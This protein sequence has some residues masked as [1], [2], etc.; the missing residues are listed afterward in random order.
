MTEYPILYTAIGDSITLGTGTILFS[1]TFVDFYASAL[2]RAT[3][4]CVRSRIYARNGSTT[5]DVKQALAS[6]TISLNNTSVVTLTAGGNDLIDAMQ[7]FVKM[8]DKS[9]LYKALHHCCQNMNWIVDY[10]S[11][12]LN[13]QRDNYMIRVVNLYNPFPNLPLANYWVQAFNDHIEDCSIEEHVKVADVFTLFRGREEKLL[14]D[15]GIHPNDEG[16]KVIAKALVET[17]ICL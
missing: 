16:Q 17:G 6:S 12:N 5:E 14:S 8:N 10:L 9:I 13:K 11:T 2:K 7:D 1:P 4:N 3:K 15:D